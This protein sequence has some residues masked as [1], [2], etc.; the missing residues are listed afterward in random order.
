MAKKSALATADYTVNK[1]NI[2]N[3]DD[4]VQLLQLGC[5]NISDRIALNNKLCP[6]ILV[7][8]SHALEHRPEQSVFPLKKVVCSTS[9]D[10]QST[11]FQKKTNLGTRAE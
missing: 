7:S 10:H 6:T 9:D 4:M 5:T 1:T 2:L 8:R 3:S 11:Y